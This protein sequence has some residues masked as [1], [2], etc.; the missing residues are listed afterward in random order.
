MSDF[1]T[2]WKVT[3]SDRIVEGRGYLLPDIYKLG[4]ENRIYNFS[5]SNIDGKRKIEVNLMTGV[6]KIGEYYLDLTECL[7]RKEFFRLIY[8]RRAR[9]KA[10]ERSF[11]NREE[12]NPTYTY[13]IGWQTTIDGKN[14]QRILEMDEY[15]DTILRIRVKR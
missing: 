15:L 11:I 12:L 7:P 4:K 6:F 3:L 1:T 10:N 8:I 13:L 9:A 14:Y 2:K 5:L